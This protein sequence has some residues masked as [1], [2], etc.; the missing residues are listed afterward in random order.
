VGKY[1][2]RC[3]GR[4]VYK[5]HHNPLLFVS[6]EGFHEYRNPYLHVTQAHMDKSALGDGASRAGRCLALLLWHRVFWHGS[7]S[8][9][10]ITVPYRVAC[11]L[12]LK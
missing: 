3:K 5:S 8:R 11:R 6:R 1:S 2:K 4:V 12:H 7:G 9:T 10:A